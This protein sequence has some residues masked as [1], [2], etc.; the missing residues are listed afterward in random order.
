MEMLLEML[1]HRI[2]RHG[3]LE[4]VTFSENRFVFGDQ[5]GEPVIIRFNDRRAQWAFMIDPYLYVGE[6]YSDGRLIVEH[7]SIYD[8][9]AIVLSNMKGAK[10]PL[11]ERIIDMGRYALRHIRQFNVGSRAKRNIAHHYDF[12]ARLYALFLDSDRQYSC[13]YFEHPGQSLDEAQLAKKRHIAAKLLIEQGNRVLDIGCGWGGLAL[14][15]AGTANAEVRGITLSEEQYEVAVN[16]AHDEGISDRT[17]FALEDYR[18]TQ[19]HFDRIVSVGMLE[20]V[21]VDFYETYFQTISKL[22]DANGVAVIHAICRPEGPGHTNPWI[23]KYIFP[24]GYIPAL[25]EVLPAIERSGLLVTDVEMLRVH[26]AETLRNWRERFMS[27]RS[28]A[29]ALWGEHFCRMWEF[30]LSGSETSFRYEDM[31]VF[32]IQLAKDQ[33]A[34]PIVRDY[35][36]ERENA[37]RKRESLLTSVRLAGE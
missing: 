33:T 3:H 14:Y 11:P 31:M 17:T 27:R 22:L 23:Q 12:D 4:V 15:L 1:L 37:L 25:S 24:G 10:L 36:T 9:L 6:L 16:R 35:V 34:V 29:R 7:G 32:Q 28:E 5:T 13:A 30:Y 21:G 26:Y 18:N 2:I 8:F 19:G 20:H